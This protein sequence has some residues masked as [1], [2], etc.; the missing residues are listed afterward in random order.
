MRPDRPVERADSDDVPRAPESPPSH[1]GS[2]T[3]AHRVDR[4]GHWSARPISY[5]RLSAGIVLLA[6][7]LGLN[8][9]GLD[10]PLGLHPDE[11]RKVRFIASGEQNFKHPLLMLQLGRLITAPGSNLSAQTIALRGRAISAVALTLAALVF[12]RVAR[13]CLAEP[14]AYLAALTW[15]VTPIVV[16]HAHYLKE[17]ALLTLGCWLS[18]LAFLGFWNRPNAHR[19]LLWGACCGLASA[20]HYK[21]FLLALVFALVLA[22]D[23]RRDLPRFGVLVGLGALSWILVFGCINYE[24]VPEAARA[25]AG[26]LFEA[27][28][29]VRGHGFPVGPAQ[30]VLLFHSRYSLP[31][32]TSALIAVAGYVGLI[33]YAASWRCLQTAARAVLLFFLVFHSGI[34]L[35]PL[36]AFPDF[37]RYALPQSAVVVLAAAFLIQRLLALAPTG[38]PWRSVLGAVLA[39]VFVLPPLVDSAR[40]DQNLKSDTRLRVDEVLRRVGARNPVVDLYA[41][42]THVK[43]FQPVRASREQLVAEG[44]DFAVLSNFSFDRYLFAEQLCCLEPTVYDQAA[45]YRGLLALGGDQIRPRHRSYAFSNPTIRVVP[46]RPVQDSER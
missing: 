41:T 7:S 25:L 26:V 1:S 12:W 2:E 44:H 13:R 32:G 10:F 19:A 29:I 27:K 31:D 9:W 8:L 18:I 45:R 17:D 21:G 39:A 30:G 46:L 40:L 42:R 14:F 34:E 37:G 16:V 24:I 33:W 11:P 23:R 20:A 5:S 28:H 38:A 4:D 15:S 6:L 3:G 22:S 35:T 43:P 36:K